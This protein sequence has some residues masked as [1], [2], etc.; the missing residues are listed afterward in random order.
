LPCDGLAA[1]CF[2]DCVELVAG[3]LGNTGVLG[4]LANSESAITA[5]DSRRSTALM[6]SRF[7]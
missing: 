7:A 2:K 5:P 6:K 4:A 3:L 1:F